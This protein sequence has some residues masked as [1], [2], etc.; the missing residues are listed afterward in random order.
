VVDDLQGPNA[1]NEKQAILLAARD[2]ETDDHG[3]RQ[4]KQNNVCHDVHD[5]GGDVQ[6]G[7]VDAVA[8]DE[9]VPVALDGSTRKG[10][11]KAQADRV[12][13]DHADGSP[14][15]PLEPA[16]RRQAQV[17]HQ[18][19]QL[20][21]AAGEDIN[22]SR[23]VDALCITTTDSRLSAT[24]SCIPGSE[25]RDFGTD[26]CKPC[27]VPAPG[28][29]LRVLAHVHTLTNNWNFSIGC[30]QTWIPPAPEPNMSVECGG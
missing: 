21:E 14:Y 12:A 28:I 3:N 15:R 7:L 1:K 26:V 5:G 16:L 9:N 17:K 6:G 30:S 20:G 8:L 13:D 29:W 19:R 11:G 18:Q 24:I 10:Q 27:A 22:R 4:A 23:G 25:R 2:L